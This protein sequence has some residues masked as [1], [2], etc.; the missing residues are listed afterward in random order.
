MALNLV[1]QWDL[2]KEV[3]QKKTELE[4]ISQV[5]EVI[6]IKE[7][8]MLLNGDLEVNLGQISIRMIIL[9]QVS[10]KHLQLYQKELHQWKGIER[11][12]KERINQA[13]AHTTLILPVEP[14]NGQWEVNQEEDLNIKMLFPVQELMILN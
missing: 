10:M 14:L 11:K 12:G 3:A 2:D 13:Q 4:I 9:L 7:K 6:K 8:M 1:F 5:L